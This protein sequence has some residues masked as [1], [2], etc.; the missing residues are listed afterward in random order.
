MLSKFTVILRQRIPDRLAR[1]PSRPHRLGVLAKAGPGYWISAFLVY[2]LLPVIP[3]A[4][5][6]LLVVGMMRAR[7]RL[8]E[9]GRPHPHRQPRPVAAA[10]GLQSTL[11]R[12][13]VRQMNAEA[14]VAFLRL[15]RT[16][17]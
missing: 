10:V 17:S 15:A 4:I 11:N 7:Q 5:V 1:R 12:S 6:S 3:L 13:P 16:A 9:E 8:A 14:A 2:L